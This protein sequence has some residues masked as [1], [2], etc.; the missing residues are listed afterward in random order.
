MGFFNQ[1]MVKNLGFGNAIYMADYYH[2]FDTV[3]PDRFGKYFIHLIPHLIQMANCLYEDQFKVASNNGKSLLEEM[4]P[5]DLSIEEDF[6]K[7][8]KRKKH[9]FAIYIKAN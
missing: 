7:F 1:E 2:L 6:K 4:S 9:I 8:I 3:L 5:W